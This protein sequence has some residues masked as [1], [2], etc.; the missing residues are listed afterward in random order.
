[1]V[2]VGDGAVGKTCLICAYQENRF[3]TGYEPTVCE[4]YQGPIEYEGREIDLKIWDTIGQE[5]FMAVRPVAYNDCDCFVV[6]FDLSDRDTLMNACN[7]W[8]KELMQ[9]GPKNCPKIL[10]GCKMDLREQKISQM[11]EG[12]PNDTVSTEYG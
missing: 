6:C 7:K 1:M 5:E 11:R 12:E 9:L 4:D 8:K 10:V 2:V 3:P